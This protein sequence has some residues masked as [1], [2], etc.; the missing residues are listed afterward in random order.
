MELSCTRA[1]IPAYP[2]VNGTVEGVLQRPRERASRLDRRVVGRMEQAGR[3]CGSAGV[4]DSFRPLT[5][6]L[7]ER[8]KAD[9][10]GL[11]AMLRPASE[12]APALP[13][14]TRNASAMLT[15][16]VCRCGSTAWRGIPIHNGQ[17]VRRDCSRC[18]RFIG[19]PIWYGETTGHNGQCPIE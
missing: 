11:L 2:S 13:V 17:S 4:G 18:G 8:L 14:V 6:D 5:P 15:K 7:L 3:I 12:V 16:P 1:S 9:K 10:A 19:F